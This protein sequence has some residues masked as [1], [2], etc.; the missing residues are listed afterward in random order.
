[1]RKHTLAH[2]AQHDCDFETA[3]LRVFPTP[4]GPMAPTSTR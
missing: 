3:A 2:Q 4:K 1:V